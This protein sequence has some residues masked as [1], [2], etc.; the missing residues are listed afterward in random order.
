MPMKGLFMESSEESIELFLLTKWIKN[1]WNKKKIQRIL[2][3]DLFMFERNIVYINI[4]SML[5]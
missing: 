2:S 3:S 4:C 1:E 5:L